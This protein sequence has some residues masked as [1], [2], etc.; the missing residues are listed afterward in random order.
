VSSLKRHDG[1]LQ[2]DNRAT[3]GAVP[4]FGN[5]SHYAAPTITCWHCKTVFMVN[6]LR[7][8]PRNYCRKCDRYICDGCGAVAAQPDYQHRSFDQLAE[9]VM[10]GKY[11]IAGGSTS[12]PILIPTGVIHG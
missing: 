10:S 7:T 11:T 3:G 2:I 5:A 9:M 8:R 4:G 6:P 1:E 12:N